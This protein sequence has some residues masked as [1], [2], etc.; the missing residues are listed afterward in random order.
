[1]TLLEDTSR[2][3]SAPV[4]PSRREAAKSGRRGRIVDATCALLR[5]LGAEELSVKTIAARAGVSV[6]TVYNLFESKE[7]VLSSVFDLDLAQFEQRVAAARSEDALARIFD[8]ID[9][10]ADLYR[11]D[12]GFYR[13]IMWRLPGGAGDP[14]LSVALRAPRNRFWRGMV[15]TAVEEGHLRPGTDPSVLAALLIQ[16]FGGVLSNWISNEITTD[17]LQAQARFGFAVAL[18]AFASPSVAQRLHAQI[19]RLHAA[20][21]ASRRDG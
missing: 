19:D 5:E 7:A 14:A 16:I 21:S 13:A 10:A 8:S 12:P 20:L 11:A 2:L 15:E 1:M 17:Q 4:R 18:S 3:A 9:I 6:S